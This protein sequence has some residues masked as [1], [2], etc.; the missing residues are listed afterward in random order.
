MTSLGI[1]RLPG[2]TEVTIYSP[3]KSQD[4]LNIKGVGR[5]GQ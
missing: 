3:I 1:A 2:K 5:S 4:F